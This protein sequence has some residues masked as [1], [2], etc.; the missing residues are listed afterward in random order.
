MSKIAHAL[1]DDVV[2]DAGDGSWGC[3]FGGIGNL[4][5]D[6]EGVGVE[7]RLGDEAVGEGNSEKAGESRG[8]TQEEDVPV[9]AGGFAKRELGSLGY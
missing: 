1:F 9:E 3:L 2:D 7:G 5:C 4:F 6:A 8:E